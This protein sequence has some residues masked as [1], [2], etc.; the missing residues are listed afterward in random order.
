MQEAIGVLGRSLT[1]S[2]RFQI[3]Q[4]DAALAARGLALLRNPL[5]GTYSRW[6]AGSSLKRMNQES[7]FL[8]QFLARL[9]LA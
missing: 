6:L 7:V 5:V 3:E 8:A 2:S 1:N 4:V 9:I